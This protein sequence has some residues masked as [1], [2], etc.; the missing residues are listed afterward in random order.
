MSASLL[1]T[2]KIFVR[3][4]GLVTDMLKG[5]F[6][7]EMDGQ[8][9]F[10]LINALREKASRCQI[11]KIAQM[12]ESLALKIEIARQDFHAHTYKMMATKYD[13]PPEV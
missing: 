3:N 12:H 4:L 7:V 2:Q 10:M 13:L 9:A 1:K 6:P 11:P 5:T 8:Q